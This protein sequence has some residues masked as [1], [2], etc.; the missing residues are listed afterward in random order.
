MPVIKKNIELKIK[1]FF[2]FKDMPNI[3]KFGALFPPKMVTVQG[4]T[5]HYS[6]YCAIND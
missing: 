5:P 6:T 2:N 4:S 3:V 1:H